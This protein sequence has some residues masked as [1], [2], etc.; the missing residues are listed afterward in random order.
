MTFGF[1]ELTYEMPSNLVDVDTLIRDAGYG[2]EMVA[3]VK[4]GG[5]RR[6]PVA[7]GKP[8]TELIN[9]SIR[10]L[11]RTIPS[12]SSK[13]KGIILAHSIPFLAPSHIPFINLCLQGSDL[14]NIPSIGV[15]GQPCAVIHLAVQLAGFWLEKIPDDMGILVI[16]A[17]QAYSPEE[18]IF[19]GSAMGDVSLAG[20]VTKNSLQNRVLASFVH[21]EI[22]AYEGELSPE[23]DIAHFRKLNPLFIRYAI[24]SCLQRGGVN[25]NDLSYIIPHTPYTMIWDVIAELLR[26]PR[27][28]IL[29][30]YISETGHLNSN[31]SFVHYTRA[32]VE[33]K[34]KSGDLALL[35]NP[36]FGGTR[37]CTLIR[38]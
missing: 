11:G 32:T 25:L 13:V 5:L 35:V 30:D 31:D 36:G 22:I 16:G 10:K 15:S 4:S 3:R 19:F 1:E 26:Y 34:I 28:R 7:S 24:E 21:S 8:L 23:A 14:E 12:L 38:R 2:D 37:G 27:E 17:D 20:L 29:T 18:R 9:L 33:G 6:V